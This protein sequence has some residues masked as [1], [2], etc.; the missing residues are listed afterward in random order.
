MISVFATRLLSVGLALLTGLL[1]V[2]AQGQDA[3]PELSE[4]QKLVQALFEYE[5]AR[6]FQAAVTA[7]REAKISDQAILEARFLF[8][9]DEQDY[10]AVAALGPALKKQKAVFRIDD[11]V[12]FSVPEEF[13]AIIEYCSALGALENGDLTGFKRHITEAFWLSPR[14]A[15]AFAPH[16]DRLRRE[17]ALVNVKIDFSNKFVEQENEQMVDLTSLAKDSN[18]LVLHFWSPWS[19]ES[20]TH[21]PEML[22]MIEELTR[23]EVPIASVSIESGADGLK[24]AKEFRA[25]IEGKNL[26]NWIVDNSKSSLARKLRVQDLPTVTILN[27]D[28]TVMFN[29]HPSEELLWDALHKV[30]P[31]FKRPA[32]PPSE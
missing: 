10:D 23:L 24:A 3:L 27:I 30:D 9:I 15:T 2:R 17:Q 22:T 25:G 7:A 6:A 31:R 19:N 11:S 21:L 18:Y 13:Y 8:L 28:G 1:C 20:E 16:I 32:T 29:G 26:G 14:Q 4:E 12:I 5:D